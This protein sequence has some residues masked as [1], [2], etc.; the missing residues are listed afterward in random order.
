MAEFLDLPVSK[1]IDEVDKTKL[2]TTLMKSLRHP[3]WCLPDADEKSEIVNKI[4]ELS[5][6]VQSSTIP[7][8][9]KKDFHRFILSNCCMNVS[10]LMKYYLSWFDIACDVHCGAFRYGGGQGGIVH[11]FN[12]INGD[13][14]DNTFVDMSKKL[15]KQNITDF[16]GY[17]RGV[18]Q[19]D[20]YSKIP[21][22]ETILDLYQNAE[23]DV[24]FQFLELS[25]RTELN[26]KKAT[27]SAMMTEVFGVAVLVY[28]KLMRYFIKEEFDMDIPSLVDQMKLVC[29]NCGEEKPN[30]LLCAQC[31]HAKY[32]SKD[33]QLSDWKSGH[34][35]MHKMIKKGKL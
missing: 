9:R 30:L 14:I 29:W 21:P 4:L 26:M 1:W 8:S 31:K 2:P 11:V 3:P 25:C 16:F 20:R 34:Q 15:A 24:E 19:L 5:F 35:L 28:D 12:D 13:V 27:A 33:C 17:C 7:R 22:S 23:S 10:V 6:M 18:K 32:C